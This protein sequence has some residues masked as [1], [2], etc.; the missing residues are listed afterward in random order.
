MNCLLGIFLCNN[1]VHVG[2]KVICLGKD[3]VC[4]GDQVVCLGGNN[5]L[6]VCLE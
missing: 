5:V 3:I 1:V 2:K 6:H 4:L